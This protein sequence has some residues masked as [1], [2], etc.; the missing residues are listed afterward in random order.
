MALIDNYY[1]LDMHPKW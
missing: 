1:V